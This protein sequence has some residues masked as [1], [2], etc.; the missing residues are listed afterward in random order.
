VSNKEVAYPAAA[1]GKSEA[2]A[3]GAGLYCFSSMLTCYSCGF[4]SACF[5][6]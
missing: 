4:S 1:F 6:I 5:A 2:A 3:A